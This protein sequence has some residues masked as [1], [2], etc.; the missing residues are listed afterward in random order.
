MFNKYGEPTLSVIEECD[1]N[2]LND[3]EIYW[4]SVTNNINISAGGSEGLYGF[5]SPKCSYSK[6]QLLVVAEMLLNV[7]YTDEGISKLT[8]VSSGTIEGIRRGKRHNWL[9]EES[10]DLWLKLIDTSRYSA[11]QQRRFKSH[12]ILQDSYGNQYTVKNITA[13]AKEHG[14]NTGH[15]CSLVRGEI[16]YHKG[17]ILIKNLKGGSD[18]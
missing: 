14:L 5:N 7:N 18:E 11:A 16:L 17:F 1:I 10:P 3:R 2:M 9:K 13:F 12:C 4:I 8:G 15:L 6:E